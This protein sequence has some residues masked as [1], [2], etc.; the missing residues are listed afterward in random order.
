MNARQVPNAETPRTLVIGG[1]VHIPCGPYGRLAV[2]GIT[3]TKSGPNQ[4]EVICLATDQ[5]TGV[6]Y[7]N[8][9]V[10]K[11]VD[12]FPGARSFAGDLDK[13]EGSS[14]TFTNVVIAIPMMYRGDAQVLCVSQYLRDKIGFLKV[15]RRRLSDALREAEHA[16]TREA[17]QN[18][19]PHSM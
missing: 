3:P 9:L 10:E 19:K 5:V 15:V 18:W 2:L 13:I 11:L 6:P 8:Y 7:P 17:T 16:Y 12:K 1:M 14:G 4:F